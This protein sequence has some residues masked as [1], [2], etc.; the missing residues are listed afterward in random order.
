MLSDRLSDKSRAHVLVDAVRHHDENIADLN[1]KDAIVD[2]NLCI[3]SKRSSE[4]RLLGRHDDAVVFSERL[5][6]TACG[7]TDTSVA[8]VE[9]VR[10]GRLHHHNAQCAD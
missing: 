1:G 8:D 2:L 4:V 7:A 3:H 5:E 6:C 9:N 10:S